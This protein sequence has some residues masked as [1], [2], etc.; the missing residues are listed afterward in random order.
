MARACHGLGR[1]KVAPANSMAAENGA[2]T[3]SKLTES[4]ATRPRISSAVVTLPA[5][6]K[7]H[8]RK[9]VAP[10]NSMAAENGAVTFSKLTESDATRPRI[11]SALV[12]LPARKKIHVRQTNCQVPNTA[13]AC[14]HATGGSV[15][16]PRHT[17]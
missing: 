1:K 17:M 5:R 13:R 11:S 16:R 15:R 4:D 3:F 12:T 14:R 9:K 6:K 8:G 10:A 7:T 2:V